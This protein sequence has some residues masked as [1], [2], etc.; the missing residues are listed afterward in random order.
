MSSASAC[1]SASRATRRP[2]LCPPLGRAFGGKARRSTRS[3][4]SAQARAAGS[5][6]ASNATC[7]MPITGRDRSPTRSR[8]SVAIRTARSSP[9]VP[10]APWPSAADRDQPVRHVPDER[11]RA[12]GV[13]GRQVHREAVGEPGPLG[14]VGDGQGE[15]HGRLVGEPEP[16]HRLERPGP[17]L[18]RGRHQVGAQPP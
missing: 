4:R 10:S 14:R 6:A 9:S 5:P 12:P 2:P 8:K 15:H 1:T 3:A 16:P 11:G 7:P 13:N 18:E 17:A